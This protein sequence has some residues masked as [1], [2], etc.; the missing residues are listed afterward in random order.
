MNQLFLLALQSTSANVAQGADSL[1]SMFA[2]PLV[3]LMVVAVLGLLARALVKRY[4]KVPP[5]KALIIYGGGRTRVVSGGAKLVIPIKEDFYFLDLRAFQFDVKLENVPNKDSVP[6]NIKASVTC[7]ISNK[8]ELLP[9]AAGVFGQEKMDEITNK[10]KAV[11]E[12]HVRLLIGQST[13][14][15][16]L[17][18]RDQF[19]AKIQ[20]EVTGELAKL[21]CEIVVLNIQ[22]VSDPHGYIEALGKPKTAEIKAEAAIKEAEQDRR[23]VLQTT[24][25]KREAEQTRASNEA[26]IALAQRDL[27]KQKA[28]FDAEVATE[29]S[30]SEQ[31][32]PLA[33]AEARRAVVAAEVGVEKSRVTAEIELQ[34]AVRAKNKAELEATVLVRADAEKGRIVTEAEG[35]AAA[36]T[37]QAEAERK[38]LEA[39]GDGQAKKTRL[40][41]LAQAEVER[42]KGEAQAAAEKA[43]LL[44][45]AEGTK[46]QLLAH[47]DGTKAELLA[48]AEG[49]KELV[50]AYANMTSEQQRLIVMK[51]VLERMPE[52]T[53]VLGEAGEKIMGQIAQAVVASLSQID[54]LTVYDSANNGHDGALRR[55]MKIAPD[56]MFEV[57]NQL[58]A[59]GLLPVVA[60]AA[61]NLGFDLDNFLLAAEN[62]GVGKLPAMASSSELSDSKGTDNQAIDSNEIR[63]SVP[64]H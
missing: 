8:E 46:A 48:Q 21:G 17:R 29:R 42:V 19:N 7:K 31:A 40:A 1:W 4:V 38:A 11:I 15:M 47:A 53:K 14:E 3:I 35:L 24:D 12:G 54:N 25:A 32:G 5:E 18:E 16:I 28:Q 57:I 10:V 52:I 64:A 9:I 43:K 63:P 13:M 50:A 51:L 30:K 59:T 39:E 36:R 45:N 55:V 33:S 20:S 2:T 27:N 60:R 41:G 49:M 26:K 61:K 23:Q 37:T 6:V 34:D 44:A 56:T 58:K 62:G 22:E